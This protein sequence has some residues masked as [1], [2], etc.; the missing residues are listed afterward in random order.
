MLNRITRSVIVKSQSCELFWKLA[1]QDL[2][3]E[4]RVGD[5]G[6]GLFQST[7]ELQFRLLSLSLD[8]LVKSSDVGRFFE[9]SASL[10][11]ISFCS[12]IRRI[13]LI[14]GVVFKEGRHQFAPPWIYDRPIGP[15]L[16]DSKL[17]FRLHL[18]LGSLRVVIYTW[19]WSLSYF[20]VSWSW[21]AFS[22]WR[23]AFLRS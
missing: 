1:H 13:G 2:F 22:Q 7:S 11:V 4:R 9:S 20:S 10:A 12:E 3:E 8:Q 5:F 6:S 17:V 23:T 16:S 18:P 21:A 19:S 15:R 14:V